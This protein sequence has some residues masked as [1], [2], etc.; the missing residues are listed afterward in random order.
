MANDNTKEIIGTGVVN[1]V[2]VIFPNMVKGVTRLLNNY[3]NHLV[4]IAQKNIMQ[5]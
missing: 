1:L 4:D 2:C 5:K 3:H